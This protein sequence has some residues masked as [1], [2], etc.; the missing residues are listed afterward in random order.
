[1]VNTASNALQVAATRVGDM[2][3][4]VVRGELDLETAPLVTSVAADVAW[5][6]PVAAAD[7][8]SGKGVQFLLDLKDVTFVDVSGLHALK[9]VHVQVA[10]RGEQLRVNPPAATNARRLLTLAVSW[11][12]LPPV[13]AQTQDHPVET[14]LLDLSEPV[15]QSADA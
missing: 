5:T 10:G 14:V 9:A 2:L 13:F 15:P 3:G 1:M 11:G 8:A 7:V 4:V 6:T 12:W